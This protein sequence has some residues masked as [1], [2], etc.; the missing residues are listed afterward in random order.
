[1]FVDFGYKK[2]AMLRFDDKAAFNSEAI[3]NLHKS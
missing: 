3:P 1:M 2:I